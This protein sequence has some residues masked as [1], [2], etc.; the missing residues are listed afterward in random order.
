[1]VRAGLVE[2]SRE[3]AMTIT[4][5]GRALLESA[6]GRINGT[7][8]RVHC[9]GYAS[10]IADMGG[11]LPEDELTGVEKPTVWMVRAGKGGIY[12][13]QFVEMGLV[14]GWAARCLP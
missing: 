6:D 14:G 2:Q 8:L 5:A 7:Y 1:L 10:W 9:P 11:E 13:P 3:S 4:D 12:A